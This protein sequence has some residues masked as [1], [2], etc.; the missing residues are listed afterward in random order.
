LLIYSSTPTLNYCHRIDGNQE[1]VRLEVKMRE[2]KS[3][4]IAP[5]PGILTALGFGLVAAAVVGGILFAI[6][7]FIGFYLII[8]FPA[9]A[10]FIV[11]FVV[12]QGITAGKI[13][14]AGV[15]ILIGA[16]CGFTTM[17][18][19]HFLDYQIAFKNDI[20]NA[21][22][23]GTTAVS[24]QV[25]QVAEDAFLKGEVKQ[26]GFM[27]FLNYQAQ[28]GITITRSSSRNGLTLT[29]GW[30]WGYFGLEVLIVM[31]IVALL[32]SS[33]ASEPF[34]ERSK[35]WYGDAVHVLSAPLEQAQ[36][37]REALKNG[38]FETAGQL[39]TRDALPAPKIDLTARSTPDGHPET[40][41]LELNEIT[42]DSKKNEK[43][44]KLETGM[45]T[46][47]ELERIMSV[48]RN[49]SPVVEA[50]DATPAIG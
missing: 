33:A 47:A 14:N 2:Y 5:F 20:K 21:I 35:A 46:Q 11:G 36:T 48:A 3:S 42:L 24:D 22:S 18:V 15:A 45:I 44:N 27:G 38:F 19:Y 23:Q 41:V 39:M 17:G 4:G 34:D 8:L 32:A 9:V 6:D 28:Q 12:S 50:S 29:N 49:V 26:T 10:G 40:I 1:S 30:A 16:I 13:R 43:S 37:I 25:E 7:H 31:F